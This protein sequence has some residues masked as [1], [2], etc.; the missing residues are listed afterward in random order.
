VDAIMDASER[1]AKLDWAVGD[2]YNG[3]AVNKLEDSEKIDVAKQD[4]ANKKDL[5]NQNDL[6]EILK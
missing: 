6:P 1:N 4:E 2:I 3:D 5:T